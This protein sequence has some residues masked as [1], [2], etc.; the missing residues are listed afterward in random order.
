[1]QDTRCS[2][3]PNTTL[4]NVQVIAEGGCGERKVG[5]VRCGGWKVGVVGGRWAHDDMPQ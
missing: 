1:M 2:K 4:H 3:F 5:V